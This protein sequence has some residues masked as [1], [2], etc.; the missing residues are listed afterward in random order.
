DLTYSAFDTNPS[1]GWAPM[2]FVA[3]ITV[4][5]S[6]P[7]TLSSASATAPPGTASSTASAS[8]TSPPSW[9]S[10]VTSCPARCQRSPRPP[11]LLP[12]PTVAI[13]IA[14]PSVAFG[15]SY[16]RKRGQCRRSYPSRRVARHYS[17]VLELV[18]N[19][20]IVRLD[21]V[22]RGVQPNVLAKLEY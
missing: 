6:I 15:H 20:P 4:L 5:P 9:P 17:S 14:V 19:T 11:P 12:R 21:S 18:G 22:G 3:S 13:F 16:L 10:C 7:V 1:G 2:R 8:D